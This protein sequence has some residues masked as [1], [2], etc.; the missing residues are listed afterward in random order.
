M[1]V[2]PDTAQSL[3]KELY[4]MGRA[5]RTVLAHPEEGQLLPGGIGVLGTLESKGS[6]RQVDLAVDLC[7]SPSALSRH[8]TELVAAGYISR[9]ADPTDGR[10]TLI[11]VTGEGR[12]LLHRV[13]GSRARGLQN[14]LADWSEDDAEQACVAVQKLRDA[15][16]THAQSITV[17]A[18]QPVSRESQEV[19]V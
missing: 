4:L 14:V 3:I 5:I 15:L 12:D 8:V 2:S 7:I 9:H 1:A 18:H 16:T 13:R 17:G 11:R 10:A 6:C 19:D